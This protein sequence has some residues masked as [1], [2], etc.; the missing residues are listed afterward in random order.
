MGKPPES[1]FAVRRAAA[2][3]VARSGLQP[4]IDIEEA[5]R[6]HVA[7]VERTH[8]PFET[9][10]AVISI[11]DELEQ[12]KVFIRATSNLF[13]E[14]FT[15][16]HE[17]A[18][19]LLPWHLPRRDCRVG[20][21][22]FEVDDSEV[23]QETEAD[24]F[25]SCVL[26]PDAW[27]AALVSEHGNDMTA[28][29]NRINDAEVSVPAALLALRRY[30]LSG[31]V[32]HA[33]SRN[34]TLATV[35]T[36]LDRP[37]ASLTL[38]ELAESSTSSGTA[39]LNGEEIRWYRMLPVVEQIPERLTDDKRSQHE[40]LMSATSRGRRND[41]ARSVAMSANGKVGGILR[42]AGNR[43]VMELY[44]TLVYR[45]ASWD[46]AELLDDEDFLLWLAEKSRNI[47]TGSTKRR[48][49]AGSRS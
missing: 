44:G 20:D 7:S 36:Q 32:F 23:T 35:G 17:L 13:R 43:P 25:A 8:W 16:A 41:E 19:L 4:P 28:L 5:L 10:D 22:D 9:V 33:T 31:W 48:R 6:S 40:I 27:F 2:H 11:A 37:P 47:A 42:E 30:L 15:M 45:L 26:L 1:K 12:T 24:I 18:H 49:A 3:Y 21:G 38:A 39:S 14:R 34:W 46:H 29:L